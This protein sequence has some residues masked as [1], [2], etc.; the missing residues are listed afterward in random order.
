MGAVLDEF[1][2]EARASPEIIVRRFKEELAEI[3][4]DMALTEAERANAG[5]APGFGNFGL[6]GLLNG[7]F[8]G[9][10]WQT[11]TIAQPYTLANA[12]AYVPLSLN[13]ILL[14]YSYMTQG[15]I[16]TVVTQPVDDA[17]AGG[18]KIKSSELDEEDLETLHRVMKRSQPLVLGR[19]LMRTVAGWV[20]YN[21]CANLQRS[22]WSAVKHA[23]YWGR[24]YGGAGL[25][26]NTDQDFRSELEVDKIRPDS[27][28]VFIPADRWELVLSN[29][30]IYDP[31]SPVPFNYYGF[32]LHTSRVMKFVW[33]DAPA[34]I[35]LRLQGWG[36]SEVER[37][38]RSINSFLKFENLIFELLDEAKIDVYKIQNF[39]SQL[40]SPAGTDNVRRRVLLSNQM[41]SYQNALVMD[42]NDDYSQ[43]TL[44]SIFAGL[45]DA[46]EQLR[47]NLCS[48]LKIPRNKLFGESA[49]GFSSGEDSL[50]NY[51]SIVRNVR[52]AAEP[53][54]LEV[55]ALR[56]QQQFGFV[57]ED[58][59]VEWP[60]LRVMKQTDEEMVNTSKQKR[61]TDLYSLG[62]YDG[63]EASE[64]LKKDGLLGTETAVLKGT[65][66]P[67][68]P[69]VEQQAF[70]AEA[71]K[72]QG[73]RR[74]LGGG[75]AVKERKAA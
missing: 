38:I 14:S 34:Y 4:R 42:K 35:R 21:A 23:I 32:P 57:P 63:R 16:Q 19:K 64:V 5:G 61:T 31:R 36:M 72:R 30:N 46:W 49:G 69:E 71:E 15:L 47:L 3:R 73:K 68:A 58:I 41:K 44:G 67:I 39:N 75:P 18:P 40:A 66:K 24:L 55:A 27:P 74:A 11:Q 53:L 12:N 7:V 51:N 17:F 29:I 56:C 37:C 45:S 59:E 28:L 2:R 60:S 62:L 54:V 65:R 50:E 6:Q 48:D 20:N 13:L 70:A 1:G 43:K 8:A 52:E 22:D 25:V 26:I 9:S 33:N 10:P